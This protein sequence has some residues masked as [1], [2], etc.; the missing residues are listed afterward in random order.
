VASF[1]ERGN[2]L[3][4][5]RSYAGHGVG[6]SIGFAPN[7]PLFDSAKYEAFN[8]VKCIYSRKRQ[9]ALAK[10]LVQTFEEQYSSSQRPQHDDEGESFRA[11]SRQYNWHYAL[12]LFVSA[13]K[14]SSF[15]SEKEWRLV[16]QHPDRLLEIG[17]IH[18]RVGRFGV[19]PHFPIPLDQSN[20]RPRFDTV[21]VGP[22]ANVEASLSALRTLADAHLNTSHV[23]AQGDQVPRLLSS[24]IPY[25]P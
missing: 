11:L 15:S 7:N 6:Y 2:D 21:F 19:V 14:H 8:L 4:Q 10:A 16:C 20:L 9:S 12:T 17:K 5:W 22:A 13:C 1:S 18:F 24:A 3:S 23:N 25:R